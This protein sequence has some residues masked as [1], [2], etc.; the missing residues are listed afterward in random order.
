M[1]ADGNVRLDVDTDQAVAAIQEARESTKDAAEDMVRQLTVLAESEMKAE[2]PTGAGRGEQLRNSIT[3][4]FEGDAK[5]SV[6]PTK[7]TRS[8]IPLADIIVDGA[9]WDAS[10]PPPLAPLSHWT[11]AK[12]GDGSTSA[13]AR[14][15]HSLVRNGTDANP[16]VDRSLDGWTGQVEQVAGAE[17]AAALG[18]AGVLR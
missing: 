14:L 1:G 5:A 8:G 4:T 11:R 13:A 9:D 15:R 16:F 18:R 2:A 7:T 17:V 12:W 10:N 3:T 6:R